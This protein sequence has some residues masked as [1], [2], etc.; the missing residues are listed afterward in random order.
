MSKS[1]QHTLLWHFVFPYL[2]FLVRS[3]S[4]SL[5]R[6]NIKKLRLCLK[7]GMD[8]FSIFYEPSKVRIKCQIAP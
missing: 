5:M 6:A 2:F 3:F 8:I 4:L 7:K 1:K